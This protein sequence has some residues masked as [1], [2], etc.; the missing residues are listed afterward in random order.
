MNREGE[1]PITNPNAPSKEQ[2]VFQVFESIAPKYDMM[3]SVLSFRMH[4]FWRRFAM[5]KMQLAP[6]GKAF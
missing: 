5:K 4:K 2:F 1:Q 3:N 6:G